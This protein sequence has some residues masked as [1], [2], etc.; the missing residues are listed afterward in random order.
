VDVE[1]DVVVFDRD[2]P[3]MSVGRVIG[4]AL[5]AL[6]DAFVPAVVVGLVLLFTLPVELL[7]GLL[8]VAAVG[9]TFAVVLVASGV[10]HARGGKPFA[11]TRLANRAL[12]AWFV[13]PP[14]TVWSRRGR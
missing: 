14:W 2:G 13:W 1:V 3:R 7:G 5:L 10:S 8:P 11:F 6:L 9:G 12:R 4:Y